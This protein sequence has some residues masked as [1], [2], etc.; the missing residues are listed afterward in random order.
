MANIKARVLQGNSIR[1]KQV[2]IG[3]STTV[4]ADITQKSIDELSD[5]EVTETDKGF[6]QYDAT[7]DKWKTATSI[8]GGTF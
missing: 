3:N 2:A 1:A 8:D 7:A 5:V 6:L 4:Q